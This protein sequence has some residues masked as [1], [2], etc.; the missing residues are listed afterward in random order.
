MPR[1]AQDRPGSR[2]RTRALGRELWQLALM[3][4]LLAAARS[5]LAN[6]YHVPTGS[7]EPTLRPGDR[8][9]VDMR[10]YGL[11][12]PFTAIELLPG[13]PPR[14]GDVAV[15]DSPLDG[16]RLIKRVVAVAGDRV[17]VRAGRLVVNGRPLALGTAVPIERFASADAVLEL[18]HGGGP[19]L[20]P[21]TVPDGQVLVLGDHRGNSVDGRMFGWVPADA[22]Y[23]RAV[24]VYYRRGDGLGWRPLRTRADLR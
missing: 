3:L 19:E 6:H 22:L 17:A 7:M 20:P 2:S 5:S 9:L 11:R 4:G 1:H 10:A 21:V 12:V 23:G 8:V 18:G 24:S 13:E 15:F 16:Q 14:A